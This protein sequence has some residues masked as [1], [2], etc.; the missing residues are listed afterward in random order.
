MIRLR[1][2]GVFE[3]R[4]ES[5]ARINDVCVLMYI[6][7][8]RSDYLIIDARDDCL[9]NLMKSIFEDAIFKFTNMLIKNSI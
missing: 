8:Q 3:K 2:K 1:L 7:H 4:V 5:K 9:L 6:A